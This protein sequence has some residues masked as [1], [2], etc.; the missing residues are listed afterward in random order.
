MNRISSVNH[1]LI[2]VS[3]AGSLLIWFPV[4]KMGHSRTCCHQVDI[5]GRKRPLRPFVIAEAN[6]WSKVLIVQNTGFLMERSSLPVVAPKKRVVDIDDILILKFA[7]L[8]NAGVY[9]SVGR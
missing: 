1:Y 9:E 3:L 2:S 4:S 6:I 7:E 5:L 8:L